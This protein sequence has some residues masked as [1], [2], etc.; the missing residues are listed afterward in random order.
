MTFRRADIALKRAGP[1]DKCR[2]TF[3]L[4]P[5][6]KPRRYAVKPNISLFDI[7]T[8]EVRA[9]SAQRRRAERAGKR[10]SAC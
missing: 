9:W 7:D 2:S 8:P 5:P 10:P 1:E 6:T 4:A 3:Q